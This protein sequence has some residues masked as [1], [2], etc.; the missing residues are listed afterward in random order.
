MGRKAG[1]KEDAL[2]TLLDALFN[3]LLQIYSPQETLTSL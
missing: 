3:G 1:K 2:D